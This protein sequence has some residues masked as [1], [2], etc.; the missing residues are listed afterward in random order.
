MVIMK[1]PDKIKV[2]KA[3]IVSSDPFYWDKAVKEKIY[4]PEAREAALELLKEDMEEVF[5]HL[6]I[7]RVSTSDDDE[8]MEAEELLWYYENNQERRLP[9]QSPGLKLSE[10]PEG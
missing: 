4:E 6:S 3:Y 8:K 2:R 5:R 1:E 7:Y 10:P 9:Y